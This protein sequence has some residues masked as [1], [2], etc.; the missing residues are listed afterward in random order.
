M[1][2]DRVARGSMPKGVLR[3]PVR[4]VGFVAV[5]G[6]QRAHSFQGSKM[7]TPEEC[8]A[9]MLKHYGKEA[10]AIHCT[11]AIMNNDGR[12]QTATDYW[13]AVYEELTKLPH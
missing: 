7:R 3:S 11:Y 10:A 4:M 8:A 2:H 9:Y 6:H 12:N 5:Q 13:R 1:I